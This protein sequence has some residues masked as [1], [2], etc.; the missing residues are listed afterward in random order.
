MSYRG[1][2]PF[3]EL[4]RIHREL[5]KTIDELLR[6]PREILAEALPPE[7]F[8]EPL[9]DV[10]ETEDEVVLKA[11]VPG[12]KKEDIKIDATEDAVELKAEAAVEEEEKRGSA[13]IKERVYR[14][15]YRRIPLPSP[16]DPS[17]AKASLKD[18]VLTIRLPKVAPAKRVSIKIE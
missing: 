10:Y 12:I 16:V 18:G 13:V 9:V 1:V 8:R 7:A 5:E 6:R 17:K 2:S 11:E 4:R 3:E 14:R 15:F